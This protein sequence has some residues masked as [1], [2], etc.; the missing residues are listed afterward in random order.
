MKNF[1][2]RFFPWLWALVFSLVFNLVGGVAFAHSIYYQAP[3][4]GYPIYHHHHHNRFYQYIYYPGAQVYY[5]PF[6]GRYYY[7]NNGY[8]T[9]AFYPPPYIRL[10]PSVTINLGGPIP[11]YY[12]PSVLSSYPV[13]VG[14]Y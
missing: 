12:H 3:V 5:S 1:R 14:F 9:Y 2:K 10:G 11:Y 7:L 6:N 4:Y 8:W 13:P